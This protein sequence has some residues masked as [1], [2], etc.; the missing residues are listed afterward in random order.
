IPP[1]TRKLTI[2]ATP[3][4]KE[5][6]PG[7]ETT[8]DVELRDAA[9]KPAQNAEGAL[10]VVDESVLALSGYK[11]ADPLNTFYFQGADDVRN[12]HLG[13]RV[14]RAKGVAL[15][16][17]LIRG[18]GGR[19][20]M[21]RAESLSPLPALGRPTAAKRSVAGEEAR[22]ANS[23]TLDSVRVGAADQPV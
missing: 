5:L 3:R 20:E 18:V 16:S 8:V 10:V 21:S 14:Q 22:E 17:Q 12:R 19:G 6:E 15:I 9:G 11:L 13:E 2:A 7:G 23:Q 1:T 4:D